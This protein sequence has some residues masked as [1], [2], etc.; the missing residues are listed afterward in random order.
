MYSDKA[1]LLQ[2]GAKSLSTAEVGLTRRQVHKFSSPL[3]RHYVAPSLVDSIL[4][5]PTIQATPAADVVVERHLIAYVRA[6]DI[7]RPRFRTNWQE[8]THLPPQEVSSTFADAYLRVLRE[9]RVEPSWGLYQ[10]ALYHQ[11]Q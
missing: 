3:C 1:H 8:N 6:K 2:H 5:A 9:E 10:F 4:P 7:P 11:C